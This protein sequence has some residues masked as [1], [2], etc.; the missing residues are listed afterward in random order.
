[1][2]S[3]TS[4]IAA[5]P[6]KR[7]PVIAGAGLLVLSDDLADLFGQLVPLVDD[8]ILA[9]LVDVLPTRL[10]TQLRRQAGGISVDALAPQHLRA[11]VDILSRLAREPVHEDGR[12]IRMRRQLGHVGIEVADDRKVRTRQVSG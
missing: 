2:I 4:A 1:M 10:R 9:V 7:F 11:V 5:G 6:R 12:G 8:E 3:E